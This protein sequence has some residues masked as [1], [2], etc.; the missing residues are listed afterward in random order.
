MFLLVTLRRRGGREGFKYEK[1][2]T[3]SKRF[4]I[5]DQYIN[6]CRYDITDD[7]AYW[8][9]EVQKKCKSMELKYAWHALIFKDKKTRMVEV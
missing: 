1:T 9:K 4:K 6:A 2:D 7:M 3:F 5:Y 8:S